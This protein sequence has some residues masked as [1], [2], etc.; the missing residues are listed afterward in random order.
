[1][2][3]RF[4]NKSKEEYLEHRKKSNERNRKYYL[5]HKDKINQW[6]KKYRQEN[7]R[8]I[9]KYSKEHSAKPEVKERVRKWK[10]KNKEKIKEMGKEWRRKNKDKKK[11]SDRNYYYKKRKDPEYV[12]REIERLRKF[13]IE[14]LDK[15][16]VSKERYYNSE[17]GKNNFKY[18]NH[19]R[20]SLIKKSKS[21]LSNE[22]IREM[23]KKYK[24]C[25]YCGSINKLEIDH[26]V[27][28]KLMGICMMDNLVL[29][30][31]KCN[32]SKSGKEVFKWC[33]EQG[34]EVPKIVLNKLKRQGIK[35]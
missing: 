5:K 10:E 31:I 2:D 33:K 25:V 34:I 26:I 3:K 17:K 23:F 15:V 9:K 11:R 24:S 27:S 4:I 22:K 19:R 35:L 30:C 14:N 28:L 1:M 8:K 16:K 20:L 6:H 32:R 13:R 7:K 12:K 18:H 21:D 29:A